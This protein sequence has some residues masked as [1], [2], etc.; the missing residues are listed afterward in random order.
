MCSTALQQRAAYRH[1]WKRR[2]VKQSS[3][4]ARWW[5]G[6]VAIRVMALTIAH[7]SSVSESWLPKTTLPPG[8][9]SVVELMA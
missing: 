5:V 2:S 3:I 9:G 4:Q 1:A 6:L 7:L 8:G